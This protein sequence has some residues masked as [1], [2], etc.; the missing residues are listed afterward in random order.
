[1]QTTT[2]LPAPNRTH[3]TCAW[4]RMEFSTIVDLIDHVDHGH[5]SDTRASA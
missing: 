2:T 1:M 4:C 3:A 5:V